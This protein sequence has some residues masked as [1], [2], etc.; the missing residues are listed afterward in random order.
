MPWLAADSKCTCAWGEGNRVC[1]SCVLKKRRCASSLRGAEKAALYLYIYIYMYENKCWR[2]PCISIL[3]GSKCFLSC[4]QGWNSAT[5]GAMWLKP[6]PGAT[7]YI[8]IYICICIS[9]TS[10]KSLFHADEFPLLMK[11]Q[12]W[13]S[14]ADCS[15][16]KTPPGRCGKTAREVLL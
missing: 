2:N 5:P 12:C 13:R 10:R 11:F 3:R 6:E 8:Y 9:A 4:F 1:L 14:V 7:M 15:Q 16:Q